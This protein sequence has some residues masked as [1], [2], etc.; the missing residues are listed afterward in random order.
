M[1]INKSN[2]SYMKDYLKYALEFEKYVYIWSNTMNNINGRARQLYSERKHLEEVCS[3]ANKSLSS[4]SEVNNRQ[5]KIKEQEAERYKRKA[6]NSV[7]A[8]IVILLVLFI[9]GCGIGF[10]FLRNP[11]QS[12]AIPRAAVAPVLGLTVMVFGSLFSGI[13]PICVGNI[14]SNKNKAAQFAEEANQLRSRSSQKRQ[15][16]I[17][18]SQKDE[19]ESN[20]AANIIE[21]SVINKR[22]EE[23]HEALLTA[24]QNLAQIYSE[25][26]LHTKYRNLNAV[27]TLYEYLETGRCNTIEGHGGIYDTYDKDL[28]RG[29]IIE[30]LVDIRNSMHRIEANQHLLYNELQQANQTLSKINSSLSE[31]EKTNAEIA[32][33][34]AISA[35]ANQQTAAAT[36]WIAWK[37]WANG[38]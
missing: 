6:K 7:I 30:T 14:T 35:V 31:I 26:V 15:E 34:T 22:Q 11:D 17:L 27:A 24:K 19:A 1:A 12:F 4:L 23:V 9:L 3:S 25:N 20:L 28:Q 37:A 13:L 8:L 21:V 2:V 16:I 5:Q 32:K 10:S 38:Y 36:S 33:N 29:L 18:S